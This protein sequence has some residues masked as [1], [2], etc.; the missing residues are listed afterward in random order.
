MKYEEYD[1]IVTHK[2]CASGLQL[3][4]ACPQYGGTKYGALVPG[5]AHQKVS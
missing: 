3:S 2:I 5:I 4:V 1:R